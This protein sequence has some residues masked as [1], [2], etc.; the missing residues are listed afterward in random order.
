MDMSDM[1]TAPDAMTTYTG[2]NTSNGKLMNIQPA[3]QAGVHVQCF[4][5][6]LTTG[7]SR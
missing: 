4:A 1:T 2:P 3:G 7:R 5:R 6:Q